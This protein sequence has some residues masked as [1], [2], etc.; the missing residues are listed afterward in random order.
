MWIPYVVIIAVVVTG[1]LCFLKLRKSK[2]I[3]KLT[4]DLWNE[5]EPTSSEVIK[6][7]GAA[8]QT[9]KATAKVNDVEAKKLQKESTRIGD[10]LAE[11]GVV[12]PKDKGKEADDNE[13]KK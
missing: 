3:D 9:L 8:E 10:Y 4:K 11:K 1:V 13:V 12:K 5:T 2:F 7:I 6:D